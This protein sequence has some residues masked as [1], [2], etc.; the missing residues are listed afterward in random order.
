ML[1][2]GKAW[3]LSKSKSDIDKALKIHGP[4]TEG[5]YENELNALFKEATGEKT[6]RTRT[7]T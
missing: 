6:G 4:Y 2:T 1:C 5:F 3:N 7:P